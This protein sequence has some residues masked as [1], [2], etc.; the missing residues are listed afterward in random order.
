MNILCAG[1][2]QG[3]VKA[4]Q[5][6]FLELTGAKVEV[7]FGAVGAM[8]E[9]LLAGEPCDVMIVTEAMISSLQADGR[10]GQSW[11]WAIV[12]EGPAAS[13]LRRRLA[14]AMA[15][16]VHFAGRVP[17]SLLHALYERADLFVHPTHY[18]GSSLVTLEAMAHG[19]AVVATR[20]GGIPDKVQDGVTGLLVEPGDPAGLASALGGLA[21]DRPR[22]EAM[23]G[24]GR[25]RVRA[26]F[27]W[28]VLIDRTLAL[29]E[30]LCRQARA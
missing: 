21:Q 25:Q 6:V 5:G 22:R 16:H 1:A 10:L 29:Y 28:N 12:G 23:G 18:E 19:R 15:P 13:R 8:K 7:R 24:A 3:L 17:D 14:P 9:A 4:L 20:A 30:D 2:A 11:A 26:A 27:A